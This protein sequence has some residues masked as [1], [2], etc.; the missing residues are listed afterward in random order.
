MRTIVII[1]AALLL[2][3]CGSAQDKPVT[4]AS[5]APTTP[6]SLTVTGTI[7]VAADSMSSE[8]EMGGACV[9]DDGYSDIESG[10]QVTVADASGKAL[11]L[12]ALEAG[13]VSEVFDEGTAV[14]GMASLC[15]F[16]F[17]VKDVS[18]SEA[19]YSVE[20]SHRG[21]VNFTREKLNES[22]ALTLG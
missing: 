1:T 2:A 8:Q 18:P 19:I 6:A 7:T 3:S 10:A 21:K 16:G 22:V 17:T 14:E 12:G 9:T 20:V 13:R 11:A 5:T 15:V 4:R